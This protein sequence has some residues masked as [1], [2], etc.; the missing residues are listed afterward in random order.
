MEEQIRDAA[1]QGDLP[2]VQ[3]IMQQRAAGAAVNLNAGDFFGSTALHKAAS[4]GHLRIVQAFLQADGVQVNARN[5]GRETPLHSVFSGHHHR[6]LVVQALLE[7]GA[8]PNAANAIS[9]N[10]PVT[11]VE[12]LLNGGA[13][14]MAR[15]FSNGT[16]LHTACRYGRLEAVQ[17]L[18]QRQGSECLTLKD[19]REKTLLDC[20][21]CSGYYASS[22]KNEAVVCIGKHILQAYAGLLVQG[23][24]IFC[25]HSVLQNASSLE[26]KPRNIIYPSERSPMSTFRYSW[27]T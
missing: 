2:T 10:A 1:T 13:D 14:P 19:T 3:R 27:S 23:Q 12:A 22:Q 20:L 21:S 17:V 5:V 25:L 9:Y 6:L 16:P 7:A 4:R 18:I 11:I 24:G 15:D 26:S 8:D